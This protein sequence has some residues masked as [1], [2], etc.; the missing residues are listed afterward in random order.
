MPPPAPA[1]M[2]PAISLNSAVP[3]RSVS[4]TCA[5]ALL[6]RLPL[7]NVP[8]EELR[9]VTTIRCVCG[10]I[11]MRAWL[12]ETVSSSIGISHWR[13]RPTMAVRPASSA[14]AFPPALGCREIA[15]AVCAKFIWA[16]G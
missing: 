10:L 3:N 14:K 5:C 8:F 1:G 2:D 12:E 13:L 4:P 15:A 6:M 16:A 9:S 7:T 11:S